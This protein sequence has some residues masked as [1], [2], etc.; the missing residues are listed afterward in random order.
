MSRE[1]D[2]IEDL[3]TACQLEMGDASDF[4]SAKGDRKCYLDAQ[5]ESA[6]SFEDEE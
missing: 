6:D 5:E 4:C 1:N 2:N 3:C